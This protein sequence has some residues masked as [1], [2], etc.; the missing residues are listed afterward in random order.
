MARL[1]PSPLLTAL[2]CGF[3]FLAVRGLAAQDTS[4]QSGGQPWEAPPPAEAP[5]LAPLAV[6]PLRPVTVIV[7]GVGVAGGLTVAGYFL[8]DL[9]NQASRGFGHPAVQGDFLGSVSGL[10]MA[11][12]FATVIAVVLPEDQGLRK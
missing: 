12:L 4:A 5:I 1:R 8:Y 11:G 3:L 9:M 6:D 7:A 10:V 2:A